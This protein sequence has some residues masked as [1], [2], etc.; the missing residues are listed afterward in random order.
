MS[1]KDQIAKIAE[2]A[3]ITKSVAERAYTA[4]VASV[5][6]DLVN[7]GKAEI[8]GIGNL[9]TVQRAARTGR[10]PRTGDKIEI[11]ASVKVSFSAG[12]VLKDAVAV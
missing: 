11:A 4:L 9:K 2:V 6:E 10:N 8:Q 1:K 5:H 7:T 3:G 12:K